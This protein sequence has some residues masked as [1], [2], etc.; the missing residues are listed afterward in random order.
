MEIIITVIIILLSIH[1]LI[2]SIKNKKCTSCD[3]CTSKDKCNSCSN[4]TFNKEKE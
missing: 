1:I 2:N 3:S 4:I